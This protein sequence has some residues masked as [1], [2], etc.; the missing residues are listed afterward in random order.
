MN[1]HNNKFW[2]AVIISKPPGSPRLYWHQDCIMWK[3]PSAYSEISPMLF[4]M[5]YLE[6]NM[7]KTKSYDKI[8]ELLGY[9]ETLKIDMWLIYHRNE[10]QPVFLY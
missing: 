1:Y 7:N 9:K 8:K 2:K 10:F 6:D 4:F 3:D 5:Y